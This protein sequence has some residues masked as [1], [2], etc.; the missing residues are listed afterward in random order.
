ME[1]MD[2]GD[3]RD[4]EWGRWRIRLPPG[5]GLWFW[6]SPIQDGCARW[7]QFDATWNGGVEQEILHSLRAFQ[8]DDRYAH[9]AN[10]KRKD[11]VD[12]GWFRPDAE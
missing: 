7:K 11:W 5:T 3:A 10:G 9:G 6:H 1:G 8:V 2:G 12:D 4:R